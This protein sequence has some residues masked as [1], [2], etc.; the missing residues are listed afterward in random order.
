MRTFVLISR[1]VITVYSIMQ[2]YFI[3]KAFSS[4]YL[5]VL[6]VLPFLFLNLIYFHC[7]Q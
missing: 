1:L 3:L 7:I 6:Q 5:A 4:I 2:F